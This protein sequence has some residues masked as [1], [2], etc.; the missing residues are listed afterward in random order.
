MTCSDVPLPGGL[1]I[2]TASPSPENSH[3]SSADFNQTGKLSITAQDPR[4]VIRA[5]HGRA[6]LNTHWLEGIDPRSRER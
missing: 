1:V 6:S 4:W 3:R 2:V 5:R